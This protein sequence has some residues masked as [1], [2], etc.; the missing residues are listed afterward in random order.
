MSDY[1]K[2]SEN[3]NGAVAHT[4][5]RRAF[6]PAHPIWISARGGDWESVIESLRRDPTLITVTGDVVQGDGSVLE[7]VTLLHTAAG[8]NLHEV[9]QRL[10][11]LGANIHAKNSQDMTALHYAVSGNSDVKVLES[12]LKAG[13]DVNARDDIG[14]CPL[15]WAVR[16]G[17]TVEI[18]NILLEWGAAIDARTNEGASPLNCASGLSDFNI[19]RHLVL[20]GAN[21][22]TRDR[23]GFTPIHSAA[24]FSPNVEI[25]EFLISAGGNVIARDYFSRTPLDWI[26]AIENPIGDDKVFIEENGKM[27][28]GLT[29]LPT[30]RRILEEAMH[31]A[32]SQFVESEE[33]RSERESAWRS[34]EKLFGNTKRFK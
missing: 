12:L 23:N 19:V 3:F 11:A 30:K 29:C 8:K 28:M 15:Y 5:A 9:V 26:A 6:D 17:T 14:W 20:K 24:A 25:L 34:L 1:D 22:H 21:V 7:N 2:F 13:A 18:V 10:I 4:G 16:W 31:T 33:E 27:Q 32:R